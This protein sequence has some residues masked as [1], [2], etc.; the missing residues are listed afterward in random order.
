MA[1]GKKRKQ[2]NDIYMY[3]N[4]VR[5][6]QTQAEQNTDG[7]EEEKQVSPQ[8]RKNQRRAMKLGFGYVTFLAGAVAAALFVCFHYVGVRADLD[9]QTRKIESLRTEI[10]SLKEKNT[11][12]Y[13]YI[14]NSVNLEEIRERAEELG[15]VYADSSQ[16]VK[17]QSAGTHEIR[18][19][20]SIPEDGEASE[21]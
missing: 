5:V 9:K 15:M 18:Q 20:E 7:Y 6:R 14:A 10:T 8:T 16:I 17:Y 19:Y 12:E 4:L 2:G 3:D 11:S 13:N 21:K 1:A